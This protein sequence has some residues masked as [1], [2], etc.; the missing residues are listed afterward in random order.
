MNKIVEKLGKFGIVEIDKTFKDLTT[1]KIGGKIKYLV[2]PENVIALIQIIDILKDNN[3]KYKVI[4][5]GSN[6][7]CSDKDYDGCVIKLGRFINDC[8]IEDNLM[9]V[10]AGASIIAAANKAMKS[11]LSGL[12]FACGIPGTV[13]GCTFMNAGA[14]KRSISDILIEA[15][16]LIDGECKWLKVKDLDY[17]YRNSIFHKHPDWIILAVKFHLTPGNSSEIFNVMQ[18]RKA[19][20]IKAQ[21]LNYPSAGSTFRNHPKYPAW[22]LIDKIGYRGKVIGGAKVSEKHVNFL[23]NNGEATYKDFITLANDIQTKVKLEYGI[24]LLMEVEKFNCK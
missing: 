21:P 18:E 23:I 4:G 19:R 5:N 16:V 10:E 2:Y 11:G 3:I 22:E 12:E 24:D 8:Y 17:S 15:F 6:I 9:I 7:L 13:G 20:R 1:L 14:Y